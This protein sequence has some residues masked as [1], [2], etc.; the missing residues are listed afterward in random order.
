MRPLPGN[1]IVAE[2][3]TRFDA[4]LAVAMLGGAGIEG[5]VLGDPAAS[6]APHHVVERV[7][8]VVVRSEVAEDATI[9]LAGDHDSNA[10]V[11]ALDAMYH[12]RRFSNRPK[13]VRYSTYAVLAGV[14]G[15]TIVAAILQAW[16]A[17]N[18][19]FP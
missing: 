6:V 7:F 18:A 1:S 5:V 8:S 13:W 11:D 19:L 4:D 3:T 17:L 15:P 12:R 9:L 14:I 2:F 16:T 10:E